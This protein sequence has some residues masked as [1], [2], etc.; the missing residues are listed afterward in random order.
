MDT[1][2]ALIAKRDELLN[3]KFFVTMFAVDIR[4]KMGREYNTVS[5]HRSL[6]YRL[7]TLHAIAA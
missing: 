7:S 1:A 6:G 2:T 5:P 3:L 4:E